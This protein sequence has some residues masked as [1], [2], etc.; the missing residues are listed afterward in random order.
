M[1]TLAKPYWIDAGSAEALVTS[2]RKGWVPFPLAPP[3]VFSD[4]SIRTKAV[5]QQIDPEAIL[6]KRGLIAVPLLW[7]CFGATRSFS[8]N[9]KLRGNYYLR[10]ADASLTYHI[11]YRE[12]PF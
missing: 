5:P 8:P 1:V 12:R 10:S 3:P 4:W 6:A 7:L 11:I 9:R 2:P